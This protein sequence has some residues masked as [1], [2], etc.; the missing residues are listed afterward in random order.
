MDKKTL[1]SDWEFSEPSWT[2]HANNCGDSLIAFMA[3]SDTTQFFCGITQSA[4]AD[5]FGMTDLPE[6]AMDA[7][8][9]YAPRIHAVAV[10]LIKKGDV[11]GSG[12]YLITSEL[13]RHY[14]L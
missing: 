11:H 7:Y 8:K 6:G 9:V 1:C 5:C 4:I 10:E 12:Y 14:F 13:A 3:M 2:P